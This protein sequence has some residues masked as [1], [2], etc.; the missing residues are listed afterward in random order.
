M[1]SRQWI[2]DVGLAAT[3]AISLLGVFLLDPGDSASG[4][5]AGFGMSG[6]GSI[7]SKGTIYELRT[8]EHREQWIEKFG[9]SKESEK[10]VAAGLDWLA[11][12]QAK[13][14]HWANDQLRADGLCESDPCTG[15]G[16]N[17]PA[18]QTG[19]ALLAFQAGGH[20]AF[21]DRTYSPNV[22]RGLDWLVANQSEDGGLYGK[23]R[24]TQYMYQHGIATFALAEACAISRA[25]KKEPDK[26]YAAALR[27]AIAFIEAEQHY[28]GGWRYNSKKDEASDTSVSGWQVLALKTAREAGV[29]VVP[30]CIDNVESFFRACET[31]KLGRTG[32]TAGSQPSTEATTGVGMLV[33][34]FL[35]HTPESSLVCDASD[36]LAEYA[37]Q[38][39]RKSM[40]TPDYYLLYNCTL[41]MH[42][43]A[44]PNWDR[45]N[46]I[47]REQL[48]A[49]QNGEKAGCSRG[50]W[51]PNSRWGNEGG[52]I[53][54]TALAVLTLEVYYRFANLEKQQK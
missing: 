39:W 5:N 22:K 26:S 47:V 30:R 7:L 35:L 19:L 21:N 17:Y 54:T 14:G 43:H 23:H 4:G 52:R 15:A 9:G 38:Q 18:A 40:R 25:W 32:Y 36:H 29:D 50:S 31:V 28:D 1:F 45:W 2:I 11:R 6:M 12:H 44:G 42:Q 46:P 24:H 16:R 10:S 34:Q 20:F 27:R 51:E 41:A 48:I 49:L 13:D 8:I 37:E 33:H 3:L 53:Y